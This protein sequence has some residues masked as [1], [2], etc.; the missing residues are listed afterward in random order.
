M[1]LRGKM[2]KKLI[3][4]FC[5]TEIEL[6]KEEER[7]GKFICPE[8][9]KEL[10]IPAKF[11]ARALAAFIDGLILNFFSILFMILLIVIIGI[12]N[13]TSI[14]EIFRP[15]Q[16]MG[17]G[18]I[19]ILNLFF[20]WIY[21]AKSESGNMQA[22]IGKRIVGIKVTDILLQRITFGTATQRFAARYFSGIILGIGFLM[23]ISDE[24]GQAL[25]DRLSKC[26]VVRGPVLK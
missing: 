25:H 26:L 10:L 16:N 17:L 22:T 15:L 4:F 7:V 12:A 6:D 9:N 20:G 2:S 21:Y 11:S 5:D 8:C 23:A 1:E 18:E 24:K 14:K 13:N 3:C 19:A